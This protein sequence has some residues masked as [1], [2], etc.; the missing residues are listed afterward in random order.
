MELC[1]RHDISGTE[2]CVMVPVALSLHVQAQ[3]L[4]VAVRKTS[5]GLV[6][7]LPTLAVRMSGRSDAARTVYQAQQSLRER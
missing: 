2:K 4:L 1:P 3:A 6:R 7:Y 5:F